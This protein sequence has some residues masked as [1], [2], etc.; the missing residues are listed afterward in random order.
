ME[1]QMLAFQAEI[2]AFKEALP[3]L[4]A[5]EHDGEFAILKDAQF[6]HLCPTYAMALDWAYEHYGLDEHF[7]VKQVAKTVHTTHFKQAR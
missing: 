1:A 6:Q 5:A 3:T 4:L 7:F 2:D